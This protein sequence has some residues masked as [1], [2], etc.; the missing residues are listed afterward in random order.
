MAKFYYQARTTRGQVVSGQIDAEDGL[1]ARILLRARMLTPLRVVQTDQ[2]KVKKKSIGRVPFKDLLIF[3]RQLAILINVGIPLIDALKILGESKRNP[4]LR[5]AII[6]IVQSLEKGNK[7]SDSLAAFDEIFDRLYVNMVAAGEEAGILDTVL[8]RLAEYQE[9]IDK[10]KK[11]LKSAMFYPVTVILI[12]IGVVTG[13]LLFI[14]PKFQELYKNSGKELPALTQM[15]IHLSQ[16]ISQKWY[17]LLGG[18]TGILF[19]LAEWARSPEGKDFLQRY[20]I[21][22]PVFGDVIQKSAL[23]KF[24]RTMATLLSSGVPLVDAIEIAGKT[25]G[26]VVI[27]EALYRAQESIKQGRPL[28]EP[29]KKERYIPEML[30]QMVRIGEASGSLDNIFGKIAEFYED[31][32]EAAIKASTSLIEPILIVVLGG[33]IAFIIVA[34]Y[35]PIFDLAS[36]SV[37][38]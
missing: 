28:Y 21:G 15:V 27:E 19:I 10:I 2:G 16:L 5:K 9:R 38:Q 13:I 6:D 7:L 32:V 11:Q 1:Q 22:I 18:T 14:V 25:A 31:D 30:V 3:T 24:C 36:V 12:A 29:L 23:A 26:N 33:I 35:L 17:M 34:L 20:L 4:R 8:K 37:Q